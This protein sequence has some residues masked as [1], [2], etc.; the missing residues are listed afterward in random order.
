MN[1]ETD[2]I[3]EQR[4]HLRHSAAHILAEVVM[5]RFPETKLT[6]GPA[7][8]NGFYYDFDSAHTFT[9]ED[10]A[11]LEKDM[12]RSIKANT[13][14]VERPLTRTE[15]EKFVA[16][17]E[18]KAEILAGIPDD[19]QLTLV[20]HS[21][22]AFSD[23]CRGGHV[24]RTG[25]VKAVKLTSI[26]GAYWRGD[27]NRPMLQRIYG[28]AWES[29]AKLDEHLAFLKEV[30]KRD[31]RRLGTELELFFFD[32]I[33]PASPFF[34]PNGTLIINH[35]FEYL[36]E[37]YVKYGYNEV[38]TPQIFNAELWKRSGHYQNYA[39]NMF[40]LQ[41]DEQE[42]GM[43]PMNCPA[44]ML[45][46]KSQLHSYR[47]LP[48]R[49]SDFGRLH[50]YERSGATHGLT[51]VRS[52]S[53]DDAHI[54]CTEA[55]IANEVSRCIDMQEE[56][57]ATFGLENAE[58]VLSLRPDKKIGSD[59]LWDTTEAILRDVLEKR[60][61]RFEA[62]E[63]EGA[64]YGPKVDVFVP[65][66]IGR[67]WQISTIQLDFAQPERFELE[68]VTQDGGR[69]QPVVIHRALIGSMERFFG[70]LLEHTAGKLPVWLAPTQVCLIPIADR[71]NEF[72]QKLQKQLLDAQIRADLDDSSE[73][74]N[75]KIRKAQLK[76]VP[77]MLVLGDSEQETETV[78][79]RTRTGEN[80]A[81]LKIQ[82]I[83]KTIQTA[84][85]TR[86]L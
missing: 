8:D 31:H 24:A 34:L 86:Q 28:T 15:A 17:N 61:V 82:Y 20:S 32:P 36:R 75:Y 44:G 47:D 45:I 4:N 29:Q 79:L 49:L 71:H 6:I 50:R 57:Y 74:M 1:A 59:E 65:D 78:A 21:D 62:I 80:T 9:P 70:I 14:F 58:Y 68:Y 48:L 81:N 19:E 18:Y 83:I 43:K 73:R 84:T 41:M 67:K 10:L 33:S 37:V 63:G 22:G 13:E 3:E 27:E 85:Q 38:I 5:K 72:A 46:Y 12:K 60:G 39:D 35:I 54:F 40:F 25:A 30:A 52:F 64:F 23:L 66:A 42:F 26:A 16:G 11:V 55:Q 76:Q 51:R 69:A 2:N 53:Q 56:I 77:Y 7:I